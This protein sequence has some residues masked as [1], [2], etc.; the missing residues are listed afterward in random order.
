M[1]RARS[2]VWLL[3]VLN[4]PIARVVYLLAAIAALVMG[5]GAPEIV[6]GG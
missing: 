4:H 2:L 5:G 1:K 3:T 6:G